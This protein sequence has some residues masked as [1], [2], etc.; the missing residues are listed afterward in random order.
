M[1]LINTD[2]KFSCKWYDVCN[3]QL[4]IWCTLRIIS[5]IYV[6][7]SIQNTKLSVRKIQ[8]WNKNLKTQCQ[9]FKIWDRRSSQRRKQFKCMN[10][11]WVIKTSLLHFHVY[12]VL[13]SSIRCIR[14]PNIIIVLIEEFDLMMHFTSKFWINLS[15]LCEKSKTWQRSDY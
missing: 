14:F 4:N 5:A 13:Q 2:V 12:I 7:L 8:L 1:I 10:L 6:S 15:W 9:M 11:W 3:T